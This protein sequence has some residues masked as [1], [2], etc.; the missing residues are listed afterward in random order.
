MAKVIDLTGKRFGRLTVIKQEG[1]DKRRHALWL[2]KCQCGNEKTIRG[3][4]LLHSGTIS[5]GC[6][7]KESAKKQMTTHGKTNTRLYPIWRGMRA[8]CYHETSPFYNEYGGRGITMCEAW[9]NDFMAFYNWAYENGYDENAPKGECTLDRIDVNGNY[10]PSNCRWVSM[11]IQ[12]KNKRKCMLITYN[13]ETHTLPE[14]AKITGI[15]YMTLR[16]RILKDHWNVEKALTTKL[17]RKQ[18]ES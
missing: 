7:K 16:R 15:N 6:L 18:R 4:D 9:E 14:W 8:R 5:C 17:N 13:G 11:E 3:S 12:N 1:Y 10:E 2:C